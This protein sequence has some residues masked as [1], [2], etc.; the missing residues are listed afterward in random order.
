MTR[1][2]PHPRDR[3]PD[4]VGQPCSQRHVRGTARPA[5][6]HGHRGVSP[7]PYAWH[8][9]LRHIGRPGCLTAGTST[10]DA[11]QVAPAHEPDRRPDSLVGPAADL[12]RHWLESA[13]PTR[14]ERA[15]AARLARAH[16]GPGSV[17][18]A[19]AFCDRVLRPES[20]RGGPPVAPA[21][22]GDEAGLPLGRRRRPP[23]Q[24][25]PP[26]LV[27]A[28]DVVR[29]ARRRLRAMVGELV[30]DA[31]DPALGR[32]LAGCAPTASA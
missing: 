5:R 12:A 29:L 16:L 11:R 10:P 32:H 22:P 30:A 20:P 2:S 26:L 24:R 19:M 14:A 4:E 17:S 3:P 8:T 18:F 6:P 9:E 31:E 7:A 15:Q 28:R 1:P 25:R 27:L 23:A 13:A 21:G